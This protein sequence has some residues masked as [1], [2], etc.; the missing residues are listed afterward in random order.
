MVDLQHVVRR[1]FDVYRNGVA[2]QRCEREGSKDQHVKRALQLVNTIS[3]SF[4][5]PEVIAPR[6]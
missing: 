2:M 3:I 6:R 5:H 4:A 1:S